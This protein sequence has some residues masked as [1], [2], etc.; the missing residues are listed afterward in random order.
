MDIESSFI[1]HV[2]K[3]KNLNIAI[4]QRIGIDFFEGPSKLVFEWLLDFYRDF[5]EIPTF[6]ILKQK[7]PEY[8]IDESNDEPLLFLIAELRKR[9]THN[10]LH[11][12]IREVADFLGKKDP[13]AA[14]EIWRQKLL[15]IDVDIRPS[16]DVSWTHNPE[17]RFKQYLELQ[18][19]QGI[20]GLPTLWPTFNQ[21]TQGLHPEDLVFILGR[22]A[23]GKT[24]AELIIAHHIWSLGYSPLI[25]TKEMSVH[26]ILRR[27]DA[28][29]FRL[30]H[31]YLRSGTLDALEEE[32]WENA[33]QEL[34]NKHDFWVSGDDDEG[35]VIGIAS[36]IDTY[37]PDICLIDGGYLLKDDHNATQQ[38]QRIGNISRDLKKLFRRTQI[39][40][41]VTFQFS[42][43]GS[44]T[45][46]TG[47]NIKYADIEMD[48]DVII[49]LFQS[50]DQLELKEIEFRILKQREG[51]K[52][53]WKCH[54]DFETMNFLELEILDDSDDSDDPDVLF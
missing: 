34:K 2:I 33:M 42:K 49:G 18:K 5:G 14:V 47:R 20:D 11:S 40:G 45:K 32:R 29:H 21:A 30:H 9:K 12:G 7:F 39:P 8:K 51:R 31:E 13:Y 19:V 4:D 37:K 27:L 23:I 16:R 48:A 10:S 26:Q 36:K 22:S 46:G 53:N 1:T 52:I 54:W 41:I 24:W 17:E 25:I 35:G 28:T 44:K 6:E 3:H 38:W 15:E 50:A 43:E